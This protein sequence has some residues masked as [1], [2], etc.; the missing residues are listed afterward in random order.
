[1]LQ[2][3]HSREICEPIFDRSIALLQPS[4]VLYFYQV[5]FLQPCCLSKYQQNNSTNHN[6]L[7]AT[8]S[9][10]M[11]MREGDHEEEEN[12]GDCSDYN[13]LHIFKYIGKSAYSAF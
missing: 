12:G 9:A 2:K 4:D 10:D 8:E 1:M 13:C 3:I 6:E 11:D 5:Y 7:T